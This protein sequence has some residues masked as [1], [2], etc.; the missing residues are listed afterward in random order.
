MTD[1]L[2]ELLAGRW[3]D[4]DT[5]A[6]AHVPTRAVHIAKSIA[7]D[8]AVLCIEHP[9]TRIDKPVGVIHEVQRK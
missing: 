6:A 8:E 4:P 7:G 5:K 3:I 9:D 1:T 2:A